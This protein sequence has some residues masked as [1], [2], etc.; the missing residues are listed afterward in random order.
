MERKAI[1]DELSPKWPYQEEYDF[2]SEDWFTRN[3]PIWE[4]ALA[5]YKGRLDIHYL[6]IGAFE[7]RSGMWMLDNI[8]THPSSRM[9]VIDPFY[10]F[11]GRDIE[12]VFSAN[13]QKKRWRLRRMSLPTTISCS[14][15]RPSHPS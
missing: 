7:G 3:I 15:T 10:R 5:S 4:V 14:M 9:T 6:E 11:R 1:A 8:L 2:S 12:P 13:L